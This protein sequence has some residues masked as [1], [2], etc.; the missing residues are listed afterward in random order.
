[1]RSK[2]GPAWRTTPRGTG[3]LLPALPGPGWPL[4]RV[5]NSLP[6]AEERP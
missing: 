4:E 1:M 6:P 3:L 5:P 2:G